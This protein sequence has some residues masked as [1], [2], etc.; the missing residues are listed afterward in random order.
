MG[1]L[2]FFYT[3]FFSWFAVVRLHGVLKKTLKHVRR[4]VIVVRRGRGRQIGGPEVRRKRFWCEEDRMHV[5]SSVG[6]RRNGREGGLGASSIYDE[7]LKDS[8]VRYR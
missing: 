2:L 4:G 1:V 5:C 7:R 3:D 8:E 6:C